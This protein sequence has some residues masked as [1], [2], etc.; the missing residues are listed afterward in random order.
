M[1]KFVTGLAA[2]CLVAAAPSAQAFENVKGA[3]ANT[4][5]ALYDYLDRGDDASDS[6]IVA[7]VFAWAQGYMSGRNLELP[8]AQQRDLTTM[9]PE[10]V[11]DRIDAICQFNRSKYLHEVVDQIYD[12]LPYRGVS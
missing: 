12:S 9:G 1:K 11:L 6:T 7:S 4:C 10:A 3:G 5:Q 8:A 2:A